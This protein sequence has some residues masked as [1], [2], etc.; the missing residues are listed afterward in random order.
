MCGSPKTTA[1]YLRGTRT[2]VLVWGPRGHDALIVMREG[3]AVQVGGFGS[4][5]EEEEAIRKLDLL[6]RLSGQ[7][8]PLRRYI[9]S[10][11]RLIGNS[12]ARYSDLRDVRDE[13]VG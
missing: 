6:C 3:R 9:P 12:W 4:R 10:N 7:P 13:D 2:R 5:R 8:F 11:L 1:Q